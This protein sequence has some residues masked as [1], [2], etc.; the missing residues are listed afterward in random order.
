MNI[1]KASKNL[2]LEH[3]VMIK[4]IDKVTHKVV[5]QH[6]GHNAATNSMLI[7]IAEYL[8]GSGVLNQG[9]AVLK[10]YTPQYISLGTMGLLNQSQDSD[11]YP[12]GIGVSNGDE[13]TRFSEY[14]STVP[15]Y[16][17]DGYD[18][19][20][21]NNRQYLGLGPMFKDRPYQGQTI[22]G[23]KYA[24]ETVCCEL[25]SPTFPRARIS[26]RDVVPE[27]EAELPQTVD[28]IY[29]AMISTGALSQFRQNGND[30]VYITEVGLWSRPDWVNSGDNGLLAGYRIA[31]PNKVNWAMN[32]DAVSDNYALEYLLNQG[33]DNPTLDQITSA[34]S[35]IAAE[36]RKILKQ[37]IIRIG[38][39]QVAQ[40]I[41][42]I[43]IGAL[44]QLGGVSNLYS[45]YNM[46]LKWNKW[47]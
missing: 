25:I 6:E 19:N 38:P 43:Q 3:N 18:P 47:T 46:T 17:A 14:M 45:N 31:P 1:T 33:V 7:G 44:D 41:W 20:Q 16:G 27:F 36:N 29:S 28:V 5:S 39:N 26:Y 11:G 2:S 23:V 40:V 12:N 4:V 15:G 9:H 42:K 10:H 22:N 35:T 34:K 13:A 37:N 30:Y 32:S 8:S 24:N 21:N